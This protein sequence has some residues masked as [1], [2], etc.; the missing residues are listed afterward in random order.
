MKLSRILRS[1][2]ESTWSKTEH[3]TTHTYQID[4]VAVDLETFSNAENQKCLY[5]SK[6]C[7]YDP[8]AHVMPNGCASASGIIIKQYL[9]F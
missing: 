2:R 4:D 7:W 5:Q 1:T 9:P 6:K 3:K 8:P